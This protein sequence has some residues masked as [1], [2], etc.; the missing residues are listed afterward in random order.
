[1]KLRILSPSSPLCM[2][3]ILPRRGGRYCW[4]SK[5]RS[6]ETEGNGII[7][8]FSVSRK[9][10]ESTPALEMGPWPRP[11]AKLLC[12][13]WLW[14]RLCHCGKGAFGAPGMLFPSKPQGR[15]AHLSFFSKR[16]SCGNV[17]VGTA[18]SDVATR[19]AVA[20]MLLLF[21]G[22]RASL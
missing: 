10:K 8:F 21:L 7:E 1:M 18:L 2:A 11:S 9:R 13:K 19:E 4:G 22:S 16:P 12:Y 20:G 17:V 15:L 14:N 3:C 6:E 5:L